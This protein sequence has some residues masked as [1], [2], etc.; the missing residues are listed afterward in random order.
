MKTFI[1]PIVVLISLAT[2]SQLGAQVLLDFTLGGNISYTF[3]TWTGNGSISS[4]GNYLQMINLPDNGGAGTSAL[5]FDL[6][7]VNAT[8]SLE[9]FVRLDPI[10]TNNASSF[11]IVLESSPGNFNVYSFSL[12]GVGNSTFT[13]LNVL[14]SS[15]TA[16]SGTLDW[17][18]IIAVN[19]GAPYSSD[20]SY[21]L[22][23]NVQNVKAIPEPTVPALALL[24]TCALA[25][26]SLR[27]SRRR[28]GNNFSPLRAK[29]TVSVL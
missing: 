29:D 13:Q 26:S 25:A 28:V 18:N 9:V 24:A 15:P 17:T 11:G 3:G 21:N 1:L 2:G 6:S 20:P 12:S 22:S 8:G 5:S 27:R 10:A 23:I 16:T 4:S 7:S 14:L 19:F